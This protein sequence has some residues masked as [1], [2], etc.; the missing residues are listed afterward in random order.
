[1]KTLVLALALLGGGAAQAA[2]PAPVVQAQA[3]DVHAAWKLGLLYRNGTGVAADAGL[4][5]HWIGSA[6]RGGLAQAMFTLSNMLAAGEGVAVDAAGAR[7]W[8]EESAALG[9]PAALQEL[10]LKE[11]DPRQS[12]LLMRQ[13]AHALQ[14]WPAQPQGASASAAAVRP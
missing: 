6:A 4:A 3:G 13:A 9:Y 12:A 14:H 11:R 1:M 2:Q 5:A 7:R 10:A 8:L